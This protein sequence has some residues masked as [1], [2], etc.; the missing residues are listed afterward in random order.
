MPTN[1]SL[2]AL[3]EANPRNQPGFDQSIEHY[4]ALRT[5]IAATP[6]SAPRRLPQLTGSAPPDWSLRR[7]R[8]SHLPPC[9]RACC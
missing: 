7:R 3:R 9:S 2:K 4:E 5:Q 1:P 8:A 6:V